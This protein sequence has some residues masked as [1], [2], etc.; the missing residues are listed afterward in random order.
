MKYLNK[1]RKLTACLI[2]SQ[3]M[4][5]SSVIAAT[6][7][8]FTL[9]ESGQVRPLALTSDS[10]LLV[11]VNTPNNAIEVFR[12]TDAG[13]SFKKSIPVGLEPVAVV[14][15]NDSE[16]WVVNHVSDSVSIVDLTDGKERVARTL[17]VGDEPRDIVF[18]GVN[19][20]QAYITTAHRGQ[21]SLNDPEYRTPGIGRADV[22]VFDANNLGDA[23]K[24]TPKTI[25]TLFA[26]TPRALAVTP[27]GKRVYAAGFKTGN[28]T[29]S[30]WEGRV[31]A[32][33]GLPGPRTDS[34]G[35]V[36]PNA[37]IIVKYNG[38]DWVDET[39]KAWDE[40]V[41]LNLPDKDVFVIDATANPPV[42]VA[43]DAGAFAGVGTILF[44]MI[45]NP[46]NGAVYVANTEARNEVRFEG[47]GE[48]HNVET[49]RGHFSENR[50]T[51]LKDG[52]VLPRHL[53][54]H[55]DYSV[56]CDYPE[57]VNAKS[58]AQP[59]GMAITDDG[60]T[61]FVAAFGSAKVGMYKTSELESDTFIPNTKR[62][63]NLSAG[64]PSGLILDQQN[65]RLYVA[66]R[67]DNGISVV[68]TTTKTET[69]HVTM[70]NPEPASVVTGRK[71]LYDAAY[72]SSAGDSSCSTC[73]VFGDMD[74]LA[75]DLGNPDGVSA[76]IPGPWRNR[77]A[78]I[79]RPDIPETFRALKGPMTTQSLRGMANHGP[80]HWRGD[81]TA[82]DEEETAQPDSGTY[83]EDK[84]FK[85]FNPAFVGLVGRNA[86]LTAE[87]MQ[88]YTDFALQI[89]Y[90]PNPIRNLDNSMTASQQAGYERFVGEKSDTF[91][92][93]E[94]CHTLNPQGNAEHNV[95]RP[96][97]FGTSGFY[98]AGRIVPQIFK[99]PHLRNMYQKVGMFG[100]AQ[101]PELIPNINTGSP[102]P[103]MGDQI[104]G[105]GFNHDGS[106]PSVFDFHLR[107]AFIF[108][109][110]GTNGINDP[111]NPGGFSKD[112]A[113]GDAQRR[114]VED[115]IMAFPSNLAP[116]VGQQATL[117]TVG[118][119]AAN[120]RIDLLVARAEAG[121]CE[122]VAHQ[123]ANRGYLYVGNGLFQSNA[124]AV[125]ISDADLRKQAAG[126]TGDEVTYTCAPVG[127]GVRLALDRNEN[128]V[129]DRDE[130]L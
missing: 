82:G 124:K 8:D 96:G 55:I 1:M 83:N 80:M 99:V 30:L 108:R 29:T 127:S 92:T 14:L 13:L 115:F 91:F 15:R 66:T 125:L 72:T 12:V 81:R 39:G 71:F 5:A 26:D 97:F 2:L 42:Q 104:R 118:S 130:T 57:S 63:I 60:G 44:N 27:D 84:A 117:T 59:M 4:F 112:R 85:E 98:N 79:G 46:V 37:G 107:K 90:P 22:W 129:F 53:N 19:R 74:Q 10:A 89:M 56:C 35:E 33:G 103:H 34:A 105:F 113:L 70:Y 58:L 121:E 87:E 106:N 77:P 65:Q 38:T 9:F 40:L 93:C 114:E 43:G 126:K 75:W 128:G 86:M 73:H 31:T 76:P 7:K 3:L 28:Q 100:F 18:A 49:V 51:V 23:F 45:V 69:S 88:A 50:I 119:V 17:L 67:F 41:K 102:N 110:K 48:F 24:G 61:L 64:G 62:Q 21:N 47:H 32:L 78:R 122:L 68:S 111:G 54:K 36:Q 95:D 94:E 25:I 116:I 101:T 16:A 120:V 52:A 6:E 123:S 109:E 20:D 11:S